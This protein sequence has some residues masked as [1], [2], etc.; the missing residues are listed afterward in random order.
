MPYSPS[1]LRD[2]IKEVNSEVVRSL[3]QEIDAVMLRWD[4]ESTITVSTP[5]GFNKIIL[6]QLEELY[7]LWIIVLHSDQRDGDY[8]TFK[9]KE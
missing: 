9:A 4:G 7:H 6:K 1:E 8:L 5:S 2:K 3:C